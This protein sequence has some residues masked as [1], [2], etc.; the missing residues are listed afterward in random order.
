MRARLAEARRSCSRLIRGVMPQSSD[1]I[2]SSEGRLAGPERRALSMRLATLEREGKHSVRR[3]LPGL[4]FFFLALSGL[5]VLSSDVP[6][7][8]AVGCWFVGTVL[9]GLWFWF[10]G[11][12]RRRKLQLKLSRTLESGRVR[13]VR[14]VASCVVE[15]EE[16]EDEGACYAFQIADDRMVFISGQEFYASAKFPSSDFALV[17]VLGPSGEVVDSFIRKNG[18]KLAP[19]RVVPA[20]VKRRL[21]LPPHLHVMAGK[22][23]QLEQLLAA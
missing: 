9:F 3:L 5:T 14:V 1:V 22:L 20:E 15:F 19:I 18:E 16:D 23:T 17:D 2:A 21:R 10:E 7:L 4:L 13:E 11:R 12:S 8:I 6:P